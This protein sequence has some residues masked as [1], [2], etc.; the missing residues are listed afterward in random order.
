MAGKK[1]Y[2]MP[3]HDGSVIRALTHLGYDRTPSIDRCDFIMFTGGAD[4]TPELY[5]EENYASQ[6]DTMRDLREV[7]TYMV[8]KRLGKKMTGICRGS[9]FLN[10][11]EG[12]RMVQDIDG[13]G[14]YKGHKA[15]CVATGAV[16]TVTSTHHQA[17][18]LSPRGEALMVEGHGV[19]FYPARTKL[20]EK[21]YK[22]VVEAYK[23]GDDIFGV[24]FHPEYDLPSQKFHETAC[25]DWWQLRLKEFLG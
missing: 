18:N 23:Y 6:I 20:A 9:Q 1:F 15:L 3:H 24:Q 10:V 14:T 25:F 4:V 13:H 16:L 7:Y 8:G 17:I 2:Y 22:E 12:G 21:D 19:G 11:M 5:G